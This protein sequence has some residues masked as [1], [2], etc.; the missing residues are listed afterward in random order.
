MIDG[1]IN[2]RWIDRQSNE[3]KNGQSENKGLNY[4]IQ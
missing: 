1:W 3:F 4:Y 2:E